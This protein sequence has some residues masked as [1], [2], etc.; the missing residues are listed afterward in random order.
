MEAA[1]QRL[2]EL[3]NLQNETEQ[4]IGY[5]DNQFG[6]AEYDELKAWVLEALEQDLLSV[7]QSYDDANHSVQLKAATP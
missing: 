6:A 1:S 3:V 2:W 4:S 5:E 7:T